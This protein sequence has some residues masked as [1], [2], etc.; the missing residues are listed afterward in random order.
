MAVDLPPIP[1]CIEQVTELK[2]QSLIISGKAG[3]IREWLGG[4][5]I[6]GKPFEVS[7]SQIDE[8]GN[9]T[10]IL[11]FSADTPYRAIGGVIFS[12]Q[13]AKMTVGGW[14]FQPPFCAENGMPH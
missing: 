7:L 11:R 4:P 10:A 9:Q 12:A 3:I 13:A 6:K 5:A 1:N 8:E 14:T 2:S